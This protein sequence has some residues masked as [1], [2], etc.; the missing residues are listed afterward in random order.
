MVTHEQLRLVE[1][2][3]VHKFPNMNEIKPQ[4]ATHVIFWEHTP[5]HNRTA[6]F[7]KK[8]PGKE[9]V[10]DR[11]CWATG[12]SRNAALRFFNELEKNVT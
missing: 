4:G 2:G 12:L 11:Q 10:W 5:T 1:G 7:I 8:T 3:N 9:E 6:I